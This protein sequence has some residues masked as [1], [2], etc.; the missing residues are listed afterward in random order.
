MLKFIKILIWMGLNAK[1]RLK[2]YWSTSF[3]NKSGTYKATRMPRCR[4]EALLSCLHFSDNKSCPEGN[5]LYKLQSFLS[6]CNK[7]F[8]AALVPG[9][10]VFIDESMVP[11]RRRLSFLQ[12]IHGKIHKYGIK[13]FKLYAEGDYT[14][15]FEVCAGK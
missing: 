7:N 1:R 5:T 10:Y 15:T 12:Y 2:D 4:F 6:I 8:Q 11:F 3:I 14:H 9:K 13:I